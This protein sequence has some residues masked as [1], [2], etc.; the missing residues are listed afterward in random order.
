MIIVSLK[1]KPAG[2]IKRHPDTNKFVIIPSG[3]NSAYEFPY[4][5]LDLKNSKVVASTNPDFVD[6]CETIDGIEIP[7]IKIG[8]YKLNEED[9]ADFILDLVI[10]LVICKFPNI[11]SL[12]DDTVS[13]FRISSLVVFAD[14]RIPDDNALSRKLFQIKIHERDISIDGMKISVTR[15][16]IRKLLSG[17]PFEYLR[18]INKIN[19]IF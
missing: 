3:V 12:T 4:Y 17:N 18:L 19:S 16:S 11:R 1:S 5:V 9:I 14:I 2:Y 6:E 7:S 10:F 8:E 13:I 15:N